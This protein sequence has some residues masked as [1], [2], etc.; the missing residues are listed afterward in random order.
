M[1]DDDPPDGYVWIFRPY[2]TTRDGRKIWAKSYGHK[3][4]R[5]L[6]PKEDA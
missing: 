6:V 5:L 3:A 4:F 1:S 2:I